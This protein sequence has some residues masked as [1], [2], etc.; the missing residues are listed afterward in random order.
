MKLIKKYNNMPIEAKAALW[1]LF[2]SVLQRGLSV[3]TTPIF[4]R[5]FTVEEYGRYNVFNSWYGIITV[6]ITLKLYS[7]VYMQG[8]V[9]FDREKEEFSATLQSLMTCMVLV[10][11]LIYLLFQEFWNSVFSLTTTEMVLMLIMVWT[12]GIFDFWSVEQRV[13]LKYLNLVYVT[14]GYSVLRP[15]LGVIAVYHADNKVVARI[16]TLALINI[17]FFTWMYLKKL[18]Q[19]KKV[20]SKRFWKYGFMFNLPLVPHFL[21]MTLLNNSDRIIIGK[22]VG[23]EASG[24]YGLAYSIAMLMTFFSEALIASIEPYFYKNIKE[25]KFKEIEKISYPLF[26]L[27]GALNILLII[28]VPEIIAVFAPASYRGAIWLMPPIAMSVYFIFMYSFFACFLFYYEKRVY[29]MCTTSTLAFLN[30][31]LN[32]IF[33]ERF[34]YIAA[35]YTTLLCY[36][37][38]VVCNYVSMSVVMKKQSGQNDVYD[39]KIILG[40]TMVYMAICFAFMYTYSNI[41]LRVLGVIILII[42]TMLCRKKIEQYITDMKVIRR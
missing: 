14:V 40:I 32:I 18:I 42:S 7:G 20:F 15:I 11:S 37:L 27:M 30:I 29:I 28:F 41:R 34:G 1:F 26:I 9:K 5:L 23:E 17:M 33:I 35:A 4:T 19:V 12:T 25:N 31:L 3:I 13:E 10:W 22:I 8:L 21:S 2:C 24:I 16:F 38:F 36:V 6:I 39:L